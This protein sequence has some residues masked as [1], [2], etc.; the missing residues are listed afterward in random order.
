MK[1]GPALA[2][3]VQSYRE[4][5]SCGVGK[6]QQAPTVSSGQRTKRQHWNVSLLNTREGR[7]GWTSV[8][9]SGFGVERPGA[10]LTYSL[11]VKLQHLEQPWN[12]DGHSRHTELMNEVFAMP[13]EILLCPPFNFQ[14]LGV[15]CGPSFVQDL[16]I[17]HLTGLGMA[18]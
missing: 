13:T 6:E 10:D 14:A 9:L 3:G 1:V 15:H 17:Y 12:R 16:C 18:P 4:E 7:Q 11:P 5:V 2:G 8:F